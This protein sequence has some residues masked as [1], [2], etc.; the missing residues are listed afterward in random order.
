MSSPYQQ[1]A[2][3]IAAKRQEAAGKAAQLTSMIQQRTEPTAALMGHQIP[4][5]APADT[6][7][8]N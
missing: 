1:H 2:D 6:A 5:A 4:E 7:P 3:R 8:N